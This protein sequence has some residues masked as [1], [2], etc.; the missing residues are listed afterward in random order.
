MKS[1]IWLIIIVVIGFIVYNQIFPP[2]SE[3]EKEVKALEE[4]FNLALKDLQQAQR[5]AGLSGVDTT[6]D[7]QG[8]I[9]KVELVKEEL[10][11]LKERL[12]EEAAIKRAAAL[13]VKVMEFLRKT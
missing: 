4:K 1:L 5:T 11:S 10:M 8:A 7:A 6:A 13:E 9:N 12:K 3:E 2:L